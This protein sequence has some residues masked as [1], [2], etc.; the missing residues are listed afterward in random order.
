MNS[1]PQIVEP[2][3]NGTDLADLFATTMADLDTRP[4]VMAGD[5]LRQGRPRRRRRV[6][7]VIA[8]GT[9]AVALLGGLGAYG[10]TGLSATPAPTVGPVATVAPEP[11]APGT[12]GTGLTPRVAALYLTRLAP[13]GTFSDYRGEEWHS[14]KKGEERSGS[15][16]VE[17]QIDR[18]EGK[19]GLGI[20]LQGSYRESIGGAESDIAASYDCDS[21]GGRGIADCT[22]TRGAD[23]SVLMTHTE[24]LP[25]GATKGTYGRAVVAD[26]LRSDGTRVLVLTGNVSNL[27]GGGTPRR[28]ITVAEAGTI[29]T[30]PVWDLFREPSAADAAEADRV[31]APWKPTIDKERDSSE[32]GV[33]EPTADPD[34]DAPVPARVAALYLKRLA[35]NGTLTDL[36]GQESSDAVNVY[37]QLDRG[38]GKVGLGVGVQAN[39]AAGQ[40][41]EKDFVDN[42]YRCD[43]DAKVGE[44]LG[45]CEVVRN[46]DGSILMTYADA[47]EDAKDPSTKAQVVHAD[48]LRRDGTRVTVSSGNVSDLK[49][50]GETRRGVTLAQVRQIALD[51]IWDLDRKP[52]AKDVAEAERV[53]NPWRLLPG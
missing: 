14:D 13:S 40:L 52:S 23:G 3:D 47:P 43:R 19:V 4:A 33:P 6:V 18:G 17:A 15:V 44:P 1:T 36:Q 10:L 9:V 49:Y 26:F 41:N 46:Q 38:E 35:P 42:F 48:Y 5:A 45:N 24:A 16:S 37:G 50:G 20:S 25:I 11:S 31:I 2:D 27:S 21:L 30:D 39:F 28:G 22:V 34:P 12:A 8:G 29:A 32:P 7:A 53:I 51:P